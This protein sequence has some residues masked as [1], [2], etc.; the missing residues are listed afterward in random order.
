MQRYLSC[1]R[2]FDKL[3]LMMRYTQKQSHFHSILI[4][5]ASKL[6]PSG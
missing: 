5:I 6:N 1:D 4:A 3:V 2:I